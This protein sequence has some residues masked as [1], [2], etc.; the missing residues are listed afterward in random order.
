MIL[1]IHN[2]YNENKDSIEKFNAV[3]D[4]Y[5]M[6]I[7]LFIILYKILMRRMILFKMFL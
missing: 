7:K 6:Y 2:N 5:G 3:Y 4:A 1:F